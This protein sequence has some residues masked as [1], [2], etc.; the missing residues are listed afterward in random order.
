[1]ILTD[2]AFEKCRR[3]VG[4]RHIRDKR[5][6]DVERRDYFRRALSC[7]AGRFE[8]TCVVPPLYAGGARSAAT[9]GV[10]GRQEQLE[11]DGRAAGDR[12]A[13]GPDQRVHA[14]RVR[15]D[16]PGPRVH[17]IARR[18]VHQPDAG[19]SVARALVQRSGHRHGVHVET[20]GRRLHVRHD[21]GAAGQDVRDPYGRQP[22]FGQLARDAGRLVCGVQR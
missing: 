3:S 16:G 11:V 7:V 5:F 15:S 14:A 1:M 13:G 12:P 17:L 19:V 9:Y 20:H 22:P 8:R 6:V 4:G 18:V 2:D 10:T 21:S